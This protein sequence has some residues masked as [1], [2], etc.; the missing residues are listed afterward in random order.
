MR[1]MLSVMVTVVIKRQ[2]CLGDRPL[3]TPVRGLL[4]GLRDE[5][6]HL[7]SG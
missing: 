4:I 6:I 3:C 7:S 5:K 1:W 2:T